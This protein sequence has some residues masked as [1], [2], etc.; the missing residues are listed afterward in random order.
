MGAPAA[1]WDG[2]GDGHSA[3]AG[4]PVQPDD[5]AAATAPPRSEESGED[6]PG[7]EVDQA[8]EEENDEEEDDEEEDGEE[9]ADDDDE[10]PSPSHEPF[11]EPPPIGT[12][13]LR[14]A[15]PAEHSPLALAAHRGCPVRVNPCVL[16]RPRW[17]RTD[18]RNPCR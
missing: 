12:L 9:N 18:P 5:E 15:Q 1:R 2:N 14:R 6:E 11:A 16:G 10:E 17:R 13:I 7:E 8:D 4:D 3:L